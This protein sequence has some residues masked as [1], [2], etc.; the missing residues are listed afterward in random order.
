MRI[1]AIV[2]VLA[3]AC[4]AALGAGCAA[5]SEQKVEPNY[6]R[7][8]ERILLQEDITYSIDEDGDFRVVF[9][10]DEGRTQ[11]GYIISDTSDYEGIEI[12]EIWSV[13]YQ[14]EEG[15]FP[16]DVANRL[17]EETFNMK[18][19]GWARD[20]DMAVYVV[21]LDADAGADELIN[22]LLLA[23]YAADDMEEALTGDK[24]EF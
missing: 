22:A 7:R 12:R 17:L 1:S 15:E 9:E 3:L 5:V 19:G 2:R 11:L 21:R 6:D 18:L 23:L 24:D 14:S 20:E 13:G 8:V 10:L 16:A 4:V